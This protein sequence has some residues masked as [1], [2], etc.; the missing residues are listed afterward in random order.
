MPRR[1]ADYAATAGWTELNLL[2]TIG[3]LI[4]G[5]GTIP[6]LAAIVLA[7]RHPPDQPNDPWGGNSLEWWTTSPPPHLNFRSLPPIRSERPVFDARMA[8]EAAVARGA[9]AAERPAALKAS[10]TRRRPAR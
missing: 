7:L 4:L 8:A 9:T 6:F 5:L 2:S 3:S 1:Y 10:A